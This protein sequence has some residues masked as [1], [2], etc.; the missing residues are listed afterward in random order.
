MMM[1]SKFHQKVNWTNDKLLKN[2]RKD[3][4][5]NN[6]VKNKRDK[7]IQQLVSKT[8]ISNKDYRSESGV[9]CT[10]SKSKQK[11]NIRNNTKTQI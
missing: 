1:T 11:K 7:H 3:R 8:N 5:K 9:Q 2:R 6:Y 4:A 10:N